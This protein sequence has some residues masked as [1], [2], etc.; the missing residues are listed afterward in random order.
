LADRLS[1]GVITAKAAQTSL[2]DKLL[3]KGSEQFL[4]GFASFQGLDEE[5]VDFLLKK[6]V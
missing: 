2:S 3:A 1:R 6:V 4:A 5:I